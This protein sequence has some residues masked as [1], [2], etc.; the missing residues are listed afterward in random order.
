VAD[1]GNNSIR[2]ITPTGL[3]STLAGTP[4][5]GA[6]TADGPAAKALFHRPTGIA[7]DTGGNI[8][9]ADF[10]NDLMRKISVANNVTTLAGSPGRPGG[11]QAPGPLGRFHYPLGVALDRNDNVYVSDFDNHT[12]RIGQPTPPVITSSA[13]A[14]GLVGQQFVYRFTAV[15]ADSLSV[16]SLPAGLTFDSM[17]NSI[18]GM[19]GGAGTFSV[20]L[21]AT[22]GKGTTT[23]T[24]SLTIGTQML[25][26]N[27]TAATGAIGQLFTYAITGGPALSPTATVTVTGLPAGLSFNNRTGVITGTLPITL[28][29]DELSELVTETPAQ[30]GSSL[31]TI[32]ATEQGVT[33]TSTL[34]LDFTEN[35]LVPVIT[36]DS[37]VYATPGKPF[38]YQIKTLAS[39]TSYTLMGPLPPGLRFDSS[40]G[41]ISGTYQGAANFQEKEIARGRRINH[42]LAGGI[43]TNVPIFASNSQGVAAFFFGIENGPSG[44][45][46]IST[47]LQVGTGEDVGIAGFILTGNA[48]KEVLI[49]GLGP[50][51]GANPANHITGALSDPVLELH[52]AS[53]ALIAS[54]DNWRDTQESAISDTAIPPK[55]DQE[56]AI[57]AYLQ[58]NPAGA[59]Y[60][61]ILTGKNGGTGVG[62]VEVYDLGTAHLSQSSQAQTANISTRGRVATGQGVVIGGFIIPPGATPDV[63]IRGIGPSLAPS[64]TDPLLDPTL[65]LYNGNGMSIATNDDWQSSQKQ[66]IIAT[67]IPPTDPRE[68]AILRTLG[69]GNY[70]A[71]LQGKNGMNGVA[72][73]EIYVL[74]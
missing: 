61:A 21:S 39:A 1:T 65:D 34:Q 51:L 43:I 46:N 2:Q 4:G 30:Q 42:N 20:T 74:H 64:I 10:E 58:S 36:S 44:A 69:A 55:S 33:A 60:T 41:L 72:L 32:T 24:L 7:V 68:A 54:N 66:Q 6:G 26:G 5:I 17:A 27:R 45:Q 11:A 40:T 35:P 70:T 67:T 48:P 28:T 13:S 47:R 25:I 14:R 63:L 50:S 37:L 15:G 22:N 23:K 59:H 3:V 18:T 71:I 16:S 19:P 53:R 12:V 57:L 8:Y 73:V 29:T 56:S 38:S 62:L 49:R 31:V 52:D 9:I